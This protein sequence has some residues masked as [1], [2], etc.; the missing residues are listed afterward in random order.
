[1]SDIFAD[2]ATV[3]HHDGASWQR[4]VLRGVFW[5]QEKRL[6]VEGG[7]QGVKT[8]VRMRVPRMADGSAPAQPGDV[9][10][11]GEGPEIGDGYGMAQ[12]RREHSC[13]VV[14]NVT[15]NTGRA[16]LAHWRID[17]E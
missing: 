4:R 8:A 15:D 13:C 9:L 2:M 17:G 7:M 11:R 5:A 3:Y 10:M 12:F 16:H 6:R 14:T 1:M